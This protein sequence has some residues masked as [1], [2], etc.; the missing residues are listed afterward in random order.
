MQLYVGLSDDFDVGHRGQMTDFEE[1]PIDGP[2]E[3]LVELLF[4]GEG[5]NVPGLVDVVARN[6]WV[7]TMLVWKGNEMLT[8]CVVATQPDAGDILG[9]RMASFLFLMLMSA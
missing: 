1:R 5:S 6:P 9:L 8:C 3:G 4:V 2:E 7:I